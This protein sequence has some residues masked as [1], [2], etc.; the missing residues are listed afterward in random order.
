M[1]HTA[2]GCLPNLFLHEADPALLCGLAR[3]RRP[4]GVGHQRLLGRVLGRARQLH[5]PLRL[6]DAGIEGL[7]VGGAVI[8]MQRQVGLMDRIDRLVEE[9]DRGR[10]IG[11]VLENAERGAIQNA[12][13]V[14]ISDLGAFLG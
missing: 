14:G 4:P 3:R 2:L 6:D 7:R 11:R 1:I 5:D 10:E 8:D 13:I 12:L 9:A